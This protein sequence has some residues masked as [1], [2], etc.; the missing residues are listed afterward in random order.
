[1][2]KWDVRFLELAKLVSSWSK[3]PSTQVGAVIVD[4]NKKVLGLGYNGFAAGVIDS[5][6]RL[7][8]RDVKYPLMIHA[9]I[10]AI[11]SAR[12][13]LTG[14]TL[15][16]HGLFTCAR[17]AAVVVNSGITRVVCH[18]TVAENPRWNAEFE[19]ASLQYAEAGV[20]VDLIG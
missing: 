11:T 4:A 16:T 8:N 10:N 17:C 5:E 14:A 3:D 20:Q 15:Y 12:C 2:E 19:L 9:E 1:M 6:E 13:D 7:T 18:R